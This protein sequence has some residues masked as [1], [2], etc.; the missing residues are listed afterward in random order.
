MR[1]S[2]FTIVAAAIM[3]AAFLVGCS[4]SQI[5][6]NAHV[7]D[8][9]VVQLKLQAPQPISLSGDMSLYCAVVRPEQLPQKLELLM[10]LTNS[11]DGSVHLTLDN[12]PTPTDY[13]RLWLRH[14]DVPFKSGVVYEARIGE[15]AW[16]RFTPVIS[17]L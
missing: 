6:P 5:P 3:I 10:S 2:S 17:T 8:L 1:S 16:L 9:G 11:P 4:K 14:L 13:M 15:N 12:N 7:Q